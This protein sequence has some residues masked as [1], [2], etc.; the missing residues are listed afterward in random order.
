MLSQLRNDAREGV[1]KL[2]VVLERRYER[3]RDA[4]TVRYRS[5]GSQLV[6]SGRTGDDAKCVAALKRWLSSVAK[7]ELRP[8]LESLSART[9]NSY[10]KMHVRG[11]RTCWGSHSCNG[12]ISLNYCLLF[13]EPEQLNYVLLH[14]L[15]HARHMNHSR[16]F[17]GLVRRFEPDYRRLDQGLNSAWK[18]IPS[19][20]GVY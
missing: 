15:C 2:G 14:E 6:L 17:W 12:T 13:L 19:W 7:S 10:S 5:G 4:K 18:Q 1:R 16:R 11:Q 3:Q 8:R 20:V 9:G